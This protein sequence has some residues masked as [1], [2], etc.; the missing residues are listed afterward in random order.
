MR[1]QK[2]HDAVQPQ[3]RINYENNIVNTRKYHN[4]LNGKEVLIDILLLSKC[5]YFLRSHSSVSDIAIIFND[6]I[7]QRRRRI[8]FNTYAS[9]KICG[10]IVF[11]NQIV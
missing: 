10:V 4:Y 11:N 9:T 3:D 7:I 1:S 6:N 8:K 5:D 2:E